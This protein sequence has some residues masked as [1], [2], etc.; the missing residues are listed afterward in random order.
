MRGAL[1]SSQRAIV[2]LE[3]EK[4]FAEKAREKKVLS[5]KMFG[6]NHP[7]EVLEIF[8][9]PLVEPIHAA[10][11]AAKIV[12]TNRQYVKTPHFYRKI[13]ILDEL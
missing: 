13:H 11:A 6:E 7:K 9:K 4:V 8:P 1:T 10:Q 12:G 3:I 2:A 5:G